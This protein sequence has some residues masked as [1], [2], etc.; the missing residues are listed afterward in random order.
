MKNT[1][2]EAFI[3]GIIEV[4]EHIKQNPIYKVVILTGYDSYFASGGTKEGLLAIQE[5]SAK[6]TDAPIYELALKCK[7]PVIAAM[8]GHGIG[9]GWTLGMFCDFIIF[10]IHLYIIFRLFFLKIWSSLNEFIEYSNPT[11]DL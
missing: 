7:I 2:S 6:Y 5:G 8:Q 3:T 9:V 4:F 10:N 11:I 1:F